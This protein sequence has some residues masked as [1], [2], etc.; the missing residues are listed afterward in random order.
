MADASRFDFDKDFALFGAIKIDLHDLK[1]FSGFQSD[2]CACFHVRYT[3]N[4]IHKTPH[5]FAK[6]RVT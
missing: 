6:V 5:I 4:E 3:G 2:S 1:R